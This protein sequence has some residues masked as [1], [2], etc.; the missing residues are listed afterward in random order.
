MADLDQAAGQSRAAIGLLRSWKNAKSLRKAAD[1]LGAIGFA[2]DGTG[3]G[4]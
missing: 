1:S 4:F 3:F 2:E